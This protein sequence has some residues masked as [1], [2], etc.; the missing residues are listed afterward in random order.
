MTTTILATQLTPAGTVSLV[1][2]DATDRAP[3]C[4]AVEVEAP[5][6]R[7][8][9]FYADTQDH[10]ARADYAARTNSPATT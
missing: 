10:E 5:G 8:A 7:R 4:L 6:R 9:R 1:R 3:A 2:W